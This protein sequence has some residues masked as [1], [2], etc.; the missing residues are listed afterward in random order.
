MTETVVARNR[1]FGRRVKKERENL[2][3]KREPLAQLSRIAASRLEMIEFGQADDS[4]LRPDELDTLARVLG[5]TVDYLVSGEERLVP[6]LTAPVVAQRSPRGPIQHTLAFS[7]DRCPHC[8][9]PAKGSRCGTC[10]HP[11][12]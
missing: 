8:Q 11:L 6:E 5:C 3:A 2:G 1:D 10:G 7:A 4:D 12:E 9:A